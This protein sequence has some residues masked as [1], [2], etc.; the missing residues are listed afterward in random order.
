MTSHSIGTLARLTVRHV[1]SR[2]SVVRR[3]S[4]YCDATLIAGRKQLLSSAY[5]TN[6][7]QIR[8]FLQRS[9]VDCGVLIKS[10]AASHVLH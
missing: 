10:N 8:Y 6:D 1:V 5:G 9:F 4:N 3:T 2:P 7:G